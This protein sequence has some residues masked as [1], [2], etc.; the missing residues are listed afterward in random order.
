MSKCAK[1]SVLVMC[2][3]IVY[4][5]MCVYV[6]M[7]GNNDIH[8]CQDSGHYKG[9]RQTEM[10]RECLP[11]CIP[12]KRMNQSKYSKFKFL[13]KFVIIVMVGPQL[14]TNYLS[15]YSE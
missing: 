2:V 14:I 6:N 1:E 7:H 10:E 9:R 4:I 11:F 3:Y 13:L 8:H 15:Y 12:C 5:Y